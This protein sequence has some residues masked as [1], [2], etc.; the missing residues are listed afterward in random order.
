MHFTFTFFL[1][2]AE[3]NKK[4]ATA[5]VLNPTHLCVE[6]E[7]MITRASKR[8]QTKNGEDS[9]VLQCE[10]TKEKITKTMSRYITLHYIVPRKKER[11]KT[12]LLLA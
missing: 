1:F 2:L 5:I 12:L 10:E 7:P 11:I 9:N 4:N 3:W 6:D 8:V